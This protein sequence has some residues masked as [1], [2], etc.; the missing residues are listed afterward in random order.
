MIRSPVEVTGCEPDP[1]MAAMKLY[2]KRPIQSQSTAPTTATIKATFASVNRPIMSAE[3]PCGV[4]DGPEAAS[5]EGIPSRFAYE[6]VRPTRRLTEARSQR[7]AKGV[8]SATKA[9][10]AA[11]LGNSRSCVLT[12]SGS[13]ACPRMECAGLPALPIGVGLTQQSAVEGCVGDRNPPPTRVARSGA[14]W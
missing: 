2:L 12:V 14:T 7:P 4:P 1:K 9:I 6:T 5:C 8:A 3:P 10:T 11:C 13:T